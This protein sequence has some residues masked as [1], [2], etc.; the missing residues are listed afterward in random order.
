M[1]K[2]RSLSERR[3]IIRR[4]I[5]GE[6]RSGVQEDYGLQNSELQ[7]YNSKANGAL[8]QTA[9]ECGDFSAGPRMPTAKPG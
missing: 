1:P 6:D 4:L 7:F 8:I 9:L 2:V 3:T 5:S